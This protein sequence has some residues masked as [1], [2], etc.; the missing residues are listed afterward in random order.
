M[1][2]SEEERRRTALLRVLEL[3]TQ[4]IDLVDAHDLPPDIAAHVDLGRHR[5]RAALGEP[6]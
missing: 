2:G 1:G 4:A 3:L 5:V 6:I